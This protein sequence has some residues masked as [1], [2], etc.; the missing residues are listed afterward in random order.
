MQTTEQKQ[1]ASTWMDDCGR[2]AEMVR[3]LFVMNDWKW[4]GKV[5]TVC[6]IQGHIWGL[7]R[8]CKKE[9]NVP[10]QW[11]LTASS[12]RITVKLRWDFYLKDYSYDVKLD[13][14]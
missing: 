1:T 11:E 9:M 6:Q 14:N 10:E 7:L 2:L 5:P 13:I 8:L 3:P 12:G 4:E